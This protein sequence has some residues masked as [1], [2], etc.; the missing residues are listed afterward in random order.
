[1]PFVKGRPRLEYSYWEENEAFLE[2]NRWRR[3]K[4]T[5]L[6][7]PASS[8]VKYSSDYYKKLFSEQH[9]NFKFGN[10][11]HKVVMKSRPEHQTTK[12][13]FSSKVLFIKKDLALNVWSEQ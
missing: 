12:L 4:Q 7:K 9:D 5:G 8:L 13:R 11:I 1:M 10:L 2:K 6:A 3:H